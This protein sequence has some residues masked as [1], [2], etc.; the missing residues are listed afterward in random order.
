MTGFGSARTLRGRSRFGA[1]SD[2]T[3]SVPTGTRSQVFG[4]MVG[5]GFAPEPG[6]SFTSAH[7]MGASM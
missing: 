5:I 6:T 3:S 7:G 2:F 4:P 1:G